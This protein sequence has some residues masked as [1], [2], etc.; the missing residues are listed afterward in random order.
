MNYDVMIIGGGPAGLMA[1]IASAETGAST[2]LIDKGEKLGRKLAISG[3]G[4]CNVTNAMPI[5]ELIRHIPGN[6]RFLHSAFA[7]FSN[8]DIIRFFEQLG[9][10]L[11]EEDH[12]RM[13]PVAN[14]AT[15]VV[16]TLVNRLRTLGVTIRLNASVSSVCYEAS[17][18]TGVQLASGETINA[19]QVILAV[20]GKS[21]PQT[22]SCGDGY[23]WAQAAGHTITDLYP[24][25]VPLTSADRFIQEKR[26]QGL[27]LRDVAVILL[28]PNGKPIQ[29]HRWDMLFTH[30][31]LSGPA[32]LRLSQFVVKALKKYKTPTLPVQIDTYPDK[33]MEDV[34]ELLRSRIK[35]APDKSVHNIWK[36]VVPDRYLMLLLE[37]AGLSPTANGRD[38]NLK[39]VRQLAALLKTFTVQ[40]NGTLPIEKAF[41]TGGGVSLN[42]I[43]PKTMASKLMPGLYFCGEILDIH[44]YTGGYNITAAFTTGHAAGTDAARQAGYG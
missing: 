11:K 12:G 8:Q 13:F 14:K 38:I 20:G 33:N 3:G 41:I 19:R 23:A 7:A 2:L 24:T 4:R 43:N 18:V 30:F 27:A 35:Q 37:T 10:P 28:K 6:G 5:D 36:S 44:G 26:L 9:I 39:T 42:E 16:H 25:E 15:V 29:T 32:I 1:A 31:G 17:G 21:V 22:G 34:Y 40:V